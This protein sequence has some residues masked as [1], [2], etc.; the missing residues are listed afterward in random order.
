MISSTGLTSEN[1]ATF[2]IDNYSGAKGYELYM[3]YDNISFVKVETKV[4]SSLMRDSSISTTKDATYTYFRYQISGNDIYGRSLYFYIKILNSLQ[5]ILATSETV[6]VHT[7][8]S[9]PENVMCAF[10]NYNVLISWDSIDFTDGNNG[11]FA[12]YKIYRSEIE[13]LSGSSISESN[14]YLL[15]NDNFEVGDILWVVDPIKRLEWYGEVSTTGEFDLTS[16][17]ILYVNSGTN[18]EV[19]LLDNLNIYRES[20]EKEYVGVTTSISY[21]DNSFISNKRYIYNVAAY[22]SY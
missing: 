10:D 12:G 22:T 15:L 5:E 11:E 3:S 4:D 1:Y 13:Q 8:P 19:P 6:N 17:G 20:S 9:I 21:L 18:I 16:T 7:Y 2:V 14:E